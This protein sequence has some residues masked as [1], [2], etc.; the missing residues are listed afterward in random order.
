MPSRRTR[1]GSL[2]S[3]NSASVA[4][5]FTLMAPV[6]LALLL[7]GVDVCR[8][9]IAYRQLQQLTSSVAWSAKARLVSATPTSAAMLP[10]S[11]TTVLEN[12]LFVTYGAARS[13]VALAVRYLV[14]PVGSTGVSDSTLYATG[15]SMAASHAGI[16]TNMK[17]GDTRIVVQASRSFKF[18]FGSGSLPLTARVSI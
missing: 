7:G 12:T 3:D 5:E 16:D 8:G 2:F 17:M 13:D 10:A 14:K 1:R 18:L 11:A 15:L 4:V 6:V 9:L